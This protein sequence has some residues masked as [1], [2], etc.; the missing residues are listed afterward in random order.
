MKNLVFPC[1]IK[2]CLPPPDRNTRNYPGILLPLLG[3][4]FTRLLFFSTFSSAAAQDRGLTVAARDIL[5]NNTAVGKQW[6]VFIAIDRYQ[7]WGPLSNPVKDARELKEILAGNYYIDEVRELYDSQATAAN[8]RRLFDELRQKTALNDSVFLFYAGHGQTDDVTKTGSWIPVDGG[9]DR[10]AQA[11]WLP[12]IQVRNMLAALPA[13]HV[14]LIADACFSGDILDTS[15]GASP[16]INNEYLRRAYGRVSRQVMTSGASETVPDASEFALRLKS[17]L[18]RSEEPCVDPEQLFISVRDVK[19]T[20]PLL[21]YI[22]GSEHQEGGSFLFFRKQNQSTAAVPAGMTVTRASPPDWVYRIPPKTDRMVYFVG[23]SDK[24]R[25]NTNY[26]EAKSGALAD[27]LSQLALYRGAQ[28]QSVHISYEK[29]GNEE[30][31]IQIKAANIDSAGLYQRAEWLGNDGTLYV[32]CAWSL[33]GGNAGLRPDLPAFFANTSLK[34]DRIYFTANAVSQQ[35]DPDELA[36]RAEENAKMQALLYLGG[37]IDCLFNDYIQENAETEIGSF[38]AAIR[39][40][41]RINMQRISFKKE[42]SRMQK[43]SDL[44]HHYYGLYSIDANAGTA[45]KIPVYECFSYFA[46]TGHNGNSITE[47][48]KAIHF[49]GSRFTYDSPGRI[50]SVVGPYIPDF[51]KTSQSDDKYIRDLGTA[52]SIS[53]EIQNLTAQCRAARGLVSAIS[54]SVTGTVETSQIKSGLTLSGALKIKDELAGDGTS[55]QLW[56]LSKADAARIG[57]GKP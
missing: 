54:V 3:V 1:I 45:E 6:A 44:N 42:S 26:L 56:E 49:N 7:E 11:N 20:Q 51:A 10:F 32:L 19:S 22:K 15:R 24:L 53:P 9:R 52:R 30:N 2:S 39:V 21:G 46:Q 12:N 50:P 8:I 55:W 40:N 16:E 34:N 29:N 38:Q 41:S 33:R 25:S 27:I 31:V 57:G 17:V 48:K 36:R 28:I 14:F 35:D 4:F 43:E 5:G 18:R 37:S 47:N 23:K 13:K